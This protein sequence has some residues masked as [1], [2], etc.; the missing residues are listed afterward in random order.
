M[1]TLHIIR[2][3][4]LTAE[5]TIG[6]WKEAQEKALY[7]TLDFI[8]DHGGSFLLSNVL[9]N[10]GNTNEILKEWCQKYQVIEV[11]SDYTNCN[12]QR[13]GKT[14]EILVRNY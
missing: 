11:P 9:E 1:L 4:V 5:F 14:T 3:I 6:K 8:N 12:Y 13:K 2:L 7:K 10:N